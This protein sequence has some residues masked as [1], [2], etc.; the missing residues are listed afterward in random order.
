MMGKKLLTL[1]FLLTWNLSAK[2][3]PPPPSWHQVKD[4][5]TI[6]IVKVKSWAWAGR[7]PSDRSMDS[8]ECEVMEAL[9]G[10]KALVASTLTIYRDGM[11]FGS[12]CGPRMDP[13]YVLPQHSRDEVAIVLATDV[14][15]GACYV[16]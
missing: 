3:G 5:P 1:A 6:L 15:Q 10:D 13:P 8:A 16:V 2:P 9:R 14:K 11:R 7:K 12:R 4:C